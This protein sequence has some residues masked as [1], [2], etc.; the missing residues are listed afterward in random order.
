MLKPPHKPFYD[1]TSIYVPHNTNCSFV[2]LP[3]SRGKAKGSTSQQVRTTQDK[4]LLPMVGHQA[5]R[6]NTSYLVSE[7][8]GKRWASPVTPAD[9]TW[10][11]RRWA[12]TLCLPAARFSH[13]NTCC[14]A[15][16]A[17]MTAACRAEAGEIGSALARAVRALQLLTSRGEKRQVNSTGVIS[18]YLSQG[19]LKQTKGAFMQ[20]GITCRSITSINRKCQIIFAEVFY[21]SVLFCFLIFIFW[22]HCN[23]KS[24]FLDRHK[25]GWWTM[26]AASLSPGGF[27]ILL[28]HFSQL[29]ALSSLKYHG[30]FHL[31]IFFNF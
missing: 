30:A 18:L 27:H 1:R 11:L 2:I 10:R 5:L 24:L 20:V 29:P 9:T 17:R 12:G 28:L 31:P 15:P 22:F 13:S 4:A 25:R 19:F 23:N 16:W 14:T 21:C 3:R 7:D 6:R 8:V 26:S